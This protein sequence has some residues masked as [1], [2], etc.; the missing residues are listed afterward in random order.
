M[1][2]SPEI[3]QAESWEVVNIDGLLL[4]DY[5]KFSTMFMIVMAKRQQS[6]LAVDGLGM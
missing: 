6:A 3:V 2:S 4:C 1:M 5:P